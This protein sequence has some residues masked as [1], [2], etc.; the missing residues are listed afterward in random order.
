[1]SFHPDDE[2]ARIDV[3]YGQEGLELHLMDKIFFDPTRSK[4]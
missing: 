1:M 3:E 2:P 4:G